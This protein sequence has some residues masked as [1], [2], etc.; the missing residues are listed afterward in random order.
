[1]G[2][3]KKGRLLSRAHGQCHARTDIEISYVTHLRIYV[4]FPHQPVIGSRRTS[5]VFDWSLHSTGGRSHSEVLSGSQLAMVSQ[6]G[7]KCERLSE[8]LYRTWASQLQSSLV[9]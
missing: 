3:G 1:M 5:K 6:M 4:T 9:L 2:H 8:H 7:V